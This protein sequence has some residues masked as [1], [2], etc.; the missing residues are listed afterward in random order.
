MRGWMAAVACAGTVL[1]GGCA[2]VFGS[3]QSFS[4][5]QASCGAQTDYGADAQSVYSALVDAYVAYRYGRL[6]QAQYCAFGNDMASHYR[7][8]T[9]GGPDA[10]RAWADYFNAQRVKAIDWRAQV[11]PTLRGG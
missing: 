3:G 6:S 2:A 11:D 5:L 7:M 9:A 8:R 1:V 4:A 10:Q